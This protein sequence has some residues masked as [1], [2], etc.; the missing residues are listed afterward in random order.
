[1]TRIISVLATTLLAAGLSAQTFAA[2]LPTSAIVNDEDASRQN[3]QRV[4]GDLSRRLEDHSGV[5]VYRE[6]EYHSVFQP[7]PLP[8]E[9]QRAQT[10]SRPQDLR[11][12]QSHRA[13]TRARSRITFHHALL[14]GVSNIKVHLA[15][16]SDNEFMRTHRAGQ[17]DNANIK[18]HR[19]GRSD[20]ANIR[21]HRAGRSDNANI[22][23]H[24]TGRSEYAN[25]IVHR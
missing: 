21:I 6:L 20:N 5:R 4:L 15:G 22:R 17:S 11:G 12:P 18:V 7:L 9:S 14:W 2:E 25:I 19:A 23:I 13:G 16:R 3:V 8:L 1:M 10:P 24:R